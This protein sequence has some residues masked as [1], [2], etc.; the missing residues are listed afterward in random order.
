MEQF[1]PG[2]DADQQVKHRSL[3]L[4]AS[5][6]SLTDGHTYLLALHFVKVLPSDW[7][8]LEILK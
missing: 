4:F 3:S 6:C 8:A 7:Q 5:D 1:D 2:V